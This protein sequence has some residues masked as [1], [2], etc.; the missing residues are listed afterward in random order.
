MTTKTTDTVWIHD[1]STAPFV[2]MAEGD[3]FQVYT[4]NRFYC[5]CTIFG[6][7]IDWHLKHG[8]APD[9]ARRFAAALTL[10]AAIASNMD[11]WRARA[12]GVGDG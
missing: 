4:E 8:A 10:A 9:F 11:E 3:L 12:Q 7:K 5:Y 1:K 2:V 6:G